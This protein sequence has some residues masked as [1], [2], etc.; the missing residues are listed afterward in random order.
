M[1]GEHELG[2][3]DAADAKADDHDANE[4]KGKIKKLFLYD[5]T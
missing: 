2:V 5:I 4:L 3:G 1:D